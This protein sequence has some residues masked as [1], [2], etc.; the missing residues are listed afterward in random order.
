MVGKAVRPRPVAGSVPKKN[1]GFF[2]RLVSSQRFLAIVGL[3]FIL[4]IAIPLARTYNQKRQVAREIAEIQKEIDSYESQNDDL[5]E[6]ISYLQSDQ[7]LE[8]QARLNLN[9][10]KP[11]EQV[12]VIEDKRPTA[13]A[14][15]GDDDGPGSNLAKWW[16]YF[17]N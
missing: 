1:H 17:F 15:L 14:A 2:Y 7:S 10:K 6:L 11:G 12:I 9:L 5:K 13:T 16:R 3:A 8:S 4:V